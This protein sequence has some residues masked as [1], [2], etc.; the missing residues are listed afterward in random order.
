MEG[1][2]PPSA[3]RPP[4]APQ[5]VH[6]RSDGE[7]EH[8]GASYSTT[9]SQSLSQRK[10]PRQIPKRRP[11]RDHN[12]TKNVHS[13]PTPRPGVRHSAIP[14]PIPF[15]SGRHHAAAEQSARATGYGSAL[16]SRQPVK[17]LLTPRGCP[18]VWVRACASLSL[19]LYDYLLPSLPFPHS[20]SNP[21]SFSLYPSLSPLRRAAPLST[22]CA[23]GWSKAPPRRRDARERTPHRAA[24][25]RHGF[26]LGARRSADCQP[27]ALSRRSAGTQKQTHTH[28]HTGSHDPLC[29]ALLYALHG[30]KK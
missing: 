19:F 10:R 11:E 28:T 5:P 3:P 30:N 21:S 8:K 18:A 9:H 20:P 7:G 2:P 16:C 13:S 17:Q 25:A 22:L 4:P 14:I 6:S 15:P 26:R 12:A 29:G 1:V 27:A 24:R 23:G